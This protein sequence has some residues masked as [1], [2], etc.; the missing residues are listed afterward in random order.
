MNNISDVQNTVQQTETS[1]D[2]LKKINNEE[3]TTESDISKDVDF[4]S[5]K[6]M[7]YIEAYDLAKQSSVATNESKIQHENTIST[8]VFNSTAQKNSSDSSISE[9]NEIKSNLQMAKHNVSSDNDTCEAY[10]IRGDQIMTVTSTDVSIYNKSFSKCL[11]F[12]TRFSIFT[13]FVLLFVFLSFPFCAVSGTTSNR[14]LPQP[15]MAQNNFLKIFEV[16]SSF[17]FINFVA[18][19]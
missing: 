19:F 1:T 3:T 14:S 13:K 11:I 7:N 8:D 2:L 10:L 18:L 12:T 5:K 9:E 15:E 16:I 4:P 17:D 6:I